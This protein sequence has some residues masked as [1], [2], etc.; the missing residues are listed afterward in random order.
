MASYSSKIFRFDVT[1]L[2]DVPLTDTDLLVSRS[3]SEKAIPRPSIEVQ[4]QETANVKAVN[5]LKLTVNGEGFP[6]RPSYRTQGKSTVVRTNYIVLET[7]KDQVCVRVF[8]LGV[9]ITPLGLMAMFA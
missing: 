7:T 8:P 3:E 9:D 2:I 1:T 4:V 6:L 5:D